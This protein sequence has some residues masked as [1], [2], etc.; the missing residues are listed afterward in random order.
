[1]YQ[2][3]GVAVETRCSGMCEKGARRPKALA[4]KFGGMKRG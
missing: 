1:M 4:V 2:G 3:C